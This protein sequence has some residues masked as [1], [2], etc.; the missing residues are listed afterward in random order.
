MTLSQGLRAIG[1][2]LVKEPQGVSRLQTYPLDDSDC[3]YPMGPQFQQSQRHD[4]SRSQPAKWLVAFVMGGD[5]ET[6]LVKMY[7]LWPKYSYD[8]SFDSLSMKEYKRI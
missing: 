1:L 2:E 4:N 8:L 7:D 6:F 5:G 3:V